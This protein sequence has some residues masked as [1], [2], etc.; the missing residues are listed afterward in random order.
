MIPIDEY[1][2]VTYETYDGSHV[3]PPVHPLLWRHVSHHHC[4]PFDKQ[5]KMSSSD[6]NGETQLKP[7][8]NIPSQHIAAL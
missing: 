2:L 1:H 3:V 4:R 6:K 5:A 7:I 8:V